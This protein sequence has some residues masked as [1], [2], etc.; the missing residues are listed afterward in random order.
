MVLLTSSNF[1][2]TIKKQQQQKT[3]HRQRDVARKVIELKHHNSPELSVTKISHFPSRKN[4]RY[5]QNQTYNVN[6]YTKN[7]KQIG[8]S[9]T[10]NR[11]FTIAHVTPTKKE[12][13]AQ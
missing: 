13:Y 10:Q 2:A 11:Q 5:K 1:K 6:C 3:N 8:Q 7:S 4:L 9:V 12:R